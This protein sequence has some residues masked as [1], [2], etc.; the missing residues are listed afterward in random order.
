[1]F[2]FLCRCRLVWC[3]ILLIMLMP[4][5]SQSQ[6]AFTSSCL[7]C[8]L[9]SQQQVPPRTNSVQW[10]F[11]QYKFL[12]YHLFFALFC[13]CFCCCFPR[14]FARFCMQEC[15]ILFFIFCLPVVCFMEI[16]YAEE[17]VGTSAIRTIHKIREHVVLR[18]HRVRERDG[19]RKRD[20]ER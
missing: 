4:V 1:M 12:V 6:F 19:K 17:F 9:L 11:G 13:C 8:S 3:V 5:W 20:G 14:L 15:E 10:H 7:A 2:A 18:A 16:A